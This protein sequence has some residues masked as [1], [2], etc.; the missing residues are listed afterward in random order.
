M[1]DID[2][3]DPTAELARLRAELSRTRE[4]LRRAEETIEVLSQAA[5]SDEVMRANYERIRAEA[6]D[7]AETAPDDGPPELG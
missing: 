3:T 2:P 1:S 7:I 5:A 6:L 4:L